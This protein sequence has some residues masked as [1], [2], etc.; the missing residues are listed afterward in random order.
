[1]YLADDNVT[2]A[3]LFLGQHNR[4]YMVNDAWPVIAEDFSQWVIEDNFCDGMPAWDKVRNRIGVG[5]D[6][7]VRTIIQEHDPSNIS[8][9]GLER[10]F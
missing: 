9:R 6:M 1:M 4:D 2:F 5:I 10:R 8:N 7:Q 3:S